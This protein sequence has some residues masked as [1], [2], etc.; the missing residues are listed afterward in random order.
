MSLAGVNE[1]SGS[2]D[3]RSL[4]LEEERVKKSALIAAYWGA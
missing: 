3:S 2:T 1:E 4:L